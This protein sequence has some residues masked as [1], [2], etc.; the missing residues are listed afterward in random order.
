MNSK[1]VISA[2]IDENLLGGL[3]LWST[4]GG[5]FTNIQKAFTEE[6]LKAPEPLQGAEVAV[7]GLKAV[8]KSLSNHKDTCL[9]VS[10]RKRGSY[11]LVCQITDTKSADHFQL[12]RVDADGEGQLHVH[13][14]PLLGE[15]K[16]LDELALHARVSTA[17]DAERAHYDGSDVGGLLVDRIRGLGGVAVRDRGGVYFVP[18]EGMAT[19]R[20]LQR[21]LRAAT[22][23][24]V[25]VVPTLR[26]EDMAALVVESLA[27]HVET[28]CHKVREDLPKMG[29]RARESRQGA[30][31]GLLSTVERYEKLLDT[32]LTSVREQIAQ[33]ND[34]LV[35]TVLASLPDTSVGAEA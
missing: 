20:K 19:V 15:A 31:S 29:D 24:V 16:Q 9:V 8:A 1:Y 10:L 4:S 23:T 35:R 13:A 30:L 3:V 18:R 26:T 21:A 32:S 34:A 5:S 14:S 25:H 7:R 28:F 22:G 27:S 11:A 2:D 12:A 6:G 33:V 17:F